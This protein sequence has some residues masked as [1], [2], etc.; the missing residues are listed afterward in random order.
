MPCSWRRSKRGFHMVLHMFHDLAECLEIVHRSGR[1]HRDMKPGN[2]LLMLHSQ[3][4]R[5]LDFG[6]AAEIGAVLLQRN[7]VAL[8]RIA[9]QAPRCIRSVLG[10]AASKR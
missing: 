1:V 2:V 6:I 7:C 9:M 5:L 4:W 3:C 10:H 8:P